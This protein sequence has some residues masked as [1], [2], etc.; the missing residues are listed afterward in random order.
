MQL[1]ANPNR[2]DHAENNAAFQRV[3]NAYPEIS[4]FQPSPEK[5]PWH[6]QAVIDLGGDVQLIN[7]WPHTLKGQRDGYRAI[8][9]ENALRGIIEQAIIDANEPP[10]DLIEDCE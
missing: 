6:W 9:G 4:P 1:Y 3:V 2:P 5:A 10:C 7:F 8:Q